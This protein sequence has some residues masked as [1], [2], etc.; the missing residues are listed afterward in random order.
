[1]VFSFSRYGS[2][3]NIYSN[4]KKHKEKARVLLKCERAMW[5][6]SSREGTKGYR[7]SAF[8][9]LI[10]H[11]LS[12]KKSFGLGSGIDWD[13]NLRAFAPSRLRVRIFWMAS[14]YLPLE[15]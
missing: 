10:A 2:S 4:R 8:F 9:P 7:E 11:W 14:L 12:T 13:S 1:M 6:N 3:D 5:L 15:I